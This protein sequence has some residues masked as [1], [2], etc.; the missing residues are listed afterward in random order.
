MRHAVS[1]VRLDL[2]RESTRLVGCRVGAMKAGFMEQDDLT[3][4]LDVLDLETAVEETLSGGPSGPISERQVGRDSVVG[5]VSREPASG[6]SSRLV[7]VQDSAEGEVELASW[8][9]KQ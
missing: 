8:V 4:H 6:E 3:L 2:A 9:E 7:W 5:R 1:I